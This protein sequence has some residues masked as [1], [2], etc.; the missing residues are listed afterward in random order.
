MTITFL[1]SIRLSIKQDTAHTIYGVDGISL[2][3][4]TG[5]KHFNRNS[6]TKAKS[7]IGQNSSFMCSQEDSLTPEKGA[8]Q[9]ASPSHS[10]KKC[11]KAPPSEV[12]AKPISCQSPI[13]LFIVSPP[14]FH[15]IY[16]TQTDYDKTIDNAGHY[17]I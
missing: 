11:N 3:T 13:D 15:S 10:Y 8:T 9:T 14:F 16:G 17:L 12:T 7:S 2:C 6:G 5:V 4:G 1:D